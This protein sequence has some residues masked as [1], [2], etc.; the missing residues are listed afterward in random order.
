MGVGLL[1]RVFST[2]APRQS[3]APTCYF[4]SLFLISFGGILFLVG[5]ISAGF[6]LVYYNLRVPRTPFLVK[7]N[8]RPARQSVH[9]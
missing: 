9:F 1:S 2:T 3:H 8:R 7:R 6:L 5:S 4:A